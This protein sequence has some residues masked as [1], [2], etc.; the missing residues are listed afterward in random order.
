MLAVAGLTGSVVFLEELKPD[1]SNQLGGPALLW[2]G[3]DTFDTIESKMLALEHDSTGRA[4]LEAKEGHSNL[5]IGVFV[6]GVCIHNLPQSVLVS[7]VRLCQPKAT[8]SQHL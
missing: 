4:T 8:R 3:G 1:P 2:T 5:V 6:K 7:L